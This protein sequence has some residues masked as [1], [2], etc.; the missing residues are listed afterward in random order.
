MN[1][2]PP[3]TLFGLSRALSRDEGRSLTSFLNAAWACQSGRPPAHLEG[4]LAHLEGFFSPTSTGRR[5]REILTKLPKIDAPRPSFIPQEIFLASPTGRGLVTPEGRVTLHLLDEHRSQEL[6]AF[7]TDEV[8]WAYRIVADLYRSWGRDRLLEALGI[9]ESALR[10]PVIAFNLMLLVNGSIG[11]ASELP[12]PADKRQ[13]QE[14]SSVLGPVIDAFVDSLRPQ[15]TR[16]ESF[17]LRGGW[18]VTETS[19]HLFDYV[20]YTTKAIWIGRSRTKQLIDRL[21]RELARDKACEASDVAQAFDAL[22]R[23][24]ATAR[25]ALASRGLAHERSGETR[26]LRKLLLASFDKAQEAHT[27]P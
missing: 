17:R 24:Y 11:E 6:I 3:D 14:L 16:S 23:A 12:I 5:L 9:R 19:R 20:T 26:S 22:V 13:E 27:E 25:P 10:I 8:A 1:V 18:V 7:Q 21:A 15:R 4:D 2:A